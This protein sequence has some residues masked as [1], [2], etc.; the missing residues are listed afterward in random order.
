MVDKEQ[1]R[2]F[3]LQGNT[4]SKVAHAMGQIEMA[5]NKKQ[6]AVVHDAA[7]YYAENHPAVQNSLKRDLNI[8][9][10]SSNMHELSILSS[11]TNEYG[12]FEADFINFCINIGDK[13]HKTAKRNA[14]IGDLILLLFE[15]KENHME[16]YEYCMKIARKMLSKTIF[17]QIYPKQISKQNN[18][19]KEMTKQEQDRKKM[20]IG[21]Y[22]EK[23]K[24]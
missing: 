24:V 5:E 1:K 19:I 23:Y 22:N 18:K 15:I 7:T 2:T 20:S 10:L 12:D 16:E 21:Q 4:T 3:K 17:T 8:Q 11:T 9:R 14:L 13:S 6:S